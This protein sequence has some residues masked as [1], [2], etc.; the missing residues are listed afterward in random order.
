M[1]IGG[2]PAVM[3]DRLSKLLAARPW[4]LADGATGTNYFAAGLEAGGAP[5]LW[6]VEHPDRV[7]A[8]HRAFVEAG[9]DIILTNSFGGTHY[10]LKLHNAQDRVREL[11]QAAAAIARRV[12]DELGAEL[13]REIVV[14]GSVGPTGELFEPVG[15]LTLAD[16]TAAFAEQAQGLAQGLE[17]GGADV[18]WIETLSSVEE[19]QAAVA[20]CATTGLPTVCTLS[21]DTNGRTMMGVTPRR[22]AELVH[23]MSP[24]PV[25]FGGNCGTGA[26]EL[27]AV[28]LRMREA[29]RPDDVLVAKSNCGVPEFVEGQIQYNGTPELMAD[30]ARLARDMGV[31]IIG[32]CCGTTP[33]HV[34]AMYDA[35]Q[36]HQP[37]EP[38]SLGEVVTRLGAV[39]AGAAGQGPLGDRPAGRAGGRGEGRRRRGRSAD[40]TPDGDCTPRF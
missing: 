19:L 15:P 26:S 9:A 7:E 25:A 18:L 16:G 30:Y 37:G 35:L 23:Q 21:F 12:A 24:R 39:S 31:R 34:R 6:N 32:G 40:T 33:E 17:G 11:N 4:L 29:M 27:M 38:P 36:A 13:G 14:A 20:G 3:T 5:E 10:R 2:R 8:L 1:A 22:V 28:L